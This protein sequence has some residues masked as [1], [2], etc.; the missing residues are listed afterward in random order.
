MYVRNIA[1]DDITLRIKNKAILIRKGG[2]AEVDEKLISKERLK[3]VWGR[4]LVIL[5]ELP[6]QHTVEKNVKEEIKKDNI[7]KKQEELQ[8]A[9]NGILNS[10]NNKDN[11]ELIKKE[12]RQNNKVNVEKSKKQTA[13]KRGRKKQS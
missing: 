1:K 10:F 2:M 11:K 13:K 3:Q 6:I 4:V 7:D 12:E 9:V 5:S 8:N